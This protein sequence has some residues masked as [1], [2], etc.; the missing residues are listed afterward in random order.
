MW[1]ANDLR[2]SL[3]QYFEIFILDNTQNFCLFDTYKPAKLA[4]SLNSQALEK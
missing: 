2:A 1:L 3:V 4:A